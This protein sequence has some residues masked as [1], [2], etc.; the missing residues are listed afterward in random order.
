[1]QNI[2]AYPDVLTEGDQHFAWKQGRI[3]FDLTLQGVEGKGVKGREGGDVTESIESF[4]LCA[5]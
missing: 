3:C 2:L 1:M 4:L 5:K